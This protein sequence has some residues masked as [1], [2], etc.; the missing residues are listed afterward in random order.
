MLNQ[1]QNQV[2]NRNADFFQFMSNSNSDRNNHISEEISSNQHIIEYKKKI[3]KEKF[4][5][6]IKN[7]DIYNFY[8]INK[9]QNQ[10]ESQRELKKKNL[11]KV[12]SELID[13]IYIECIGFN[14]NEFI[15]EKYQSIQQVSND[16]PEYASVF[17][18]PLADKPADQ[19]TS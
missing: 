18:V 9:V 4:I 17:S 11:A 19:C 7:K 8:I 1:D 3:N 13:K 10:I 12:L 2:L 15:G 16:V 14:I 6:I 5:K